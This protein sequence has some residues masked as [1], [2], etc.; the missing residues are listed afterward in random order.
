[1]VPVTPWAYSGLAMSNASAA[2]I[3][4]CNA[5]TDEG[6]NSSSS[7]LKS[8]NSPAPERRLIGTSGGA[9]RAA[10]RRSA[11][12]IEEVLRLPEIARTLMTPNDGAERRAVIDWREAIAQKP[13]CECSC[14]S[15]LHVRSSAW[16]GSI[17]DA[18]PKYLRQTF[19]LI[20]FH[21]T[22]EPCSRATLSRW[23][24]PT[25]GLNGSAECCPCVGAGQYCPGDVPPTF[26]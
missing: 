19:T 7:G 5:T 23:D 24:G 4:A 21:W 10:A 8:G 14:H 22:R 11:E 13:S 6:N 17:C 16:S 3:R 26:E 1:M 20:I 15:V 25:A 9:R 2:T 12:L 18:V